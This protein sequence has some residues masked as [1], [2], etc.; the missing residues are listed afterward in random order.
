MC[1]CTYDFVNKDKN[2]CRDRRNFNCYYF[3]RMG[4]RQSLKVTL[5]LSDAFYGENI[6]IWWLY[7]CLLIKALTAND[8]TTP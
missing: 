6:F 5:V 2:V 4:L 8:A 7:N 3:W 1:I